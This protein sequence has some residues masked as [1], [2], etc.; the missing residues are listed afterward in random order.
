MDYISQLTSLELTFIDLAMFMK[1]HFDNYINFVRILKHEIITDGEQ[2]LGVL[3]FFIP[4]AIWPN[5]PENSGLLIYEKLDLYFDNISVNYFAEGYLNSGYLGII[6]FIVLFAFLNAKMDKHFWIVNK[7]SLSREVRF[8]SLYL[9]LFGMMF[10]ILRGALLSAFP[11]TL[12]LLLA[13]Y[14]VFFILNVKI[15]KQK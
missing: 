13:V 12:G 9:S 10:F 2:L 8:T 6:I 1:G 15:S 5:K 14:I 4:R 7:G 11:L 3:L